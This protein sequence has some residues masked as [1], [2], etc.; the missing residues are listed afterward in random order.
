MLTRFQ[1]TD[2]A[3]LLNLYQFWLDDLYPRAKFA[4]GLAI[5]EKLGHTKRIQVM[6]REWIQEA[7]P[8]A[9]Y[10]NGGDPQ[11]ENKHILS[12]NE[13]AASAPKKPSS[14]RSPAAED[15]DSDGL[16]SATPKAK[17]KQDNLDLL[18]EDKCETLFVSEDEDGGR[19]LDDELDALLA[20]EDFSKNTEP[21]SVTNAGNN[22]QQSTKNDDFGDDEEAMTGMW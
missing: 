21:V 6:R 12:L 17:R 4:D 16:Y 20:E 13:I 15:I 14:L 22:T 9:S 8:R 1:Y 7:K 19:P 3:R 11:K 5:I 18:T 2:L 10:D